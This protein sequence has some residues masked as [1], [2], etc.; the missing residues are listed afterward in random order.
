MYGGSGNDV[1]RGGRGGD[2]LTGGAGN[3]K[4]WGGPGADYF[5]FDAELEYVAVQGDVYASLIGTY[6]AMGGGWVIEAQRDADETDF[7]EQTGGES[8]LAF[9]KP[10]RPSGIETDPGYR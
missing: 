2:W 8:P 1:L 5:L 4:L 6:K 7:P 9:P 10:T 3:D